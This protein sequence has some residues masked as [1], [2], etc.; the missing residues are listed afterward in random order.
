LVFSSSLLS[1][2]LCEHNPVVERVDVLDTLAS[3][4]TKIAMPG[5]AL[6]GALGALVVT[7][8]LC[9]AQVGTDLVGADELLVL[10]DD[11]AAEG[12]LLDHDRGQDETRADLDERDVGLA[13]VAGNRRQD[14]GVCGLVGV[15]GLDGLCGLLLGDLVAADPDLAVAGEGEA[16]YVVGE[17][18][19]F[20]AAGGHA[21]VVG[22]QFLDDSGVGLLVEAGVEAEDGAGALE[23]VAG[24]VELL[25]CVDVLAVHFDSR[26]VRRLGQPEVEILALAGLEEHD[27]V[28]VVEVGKLVELRELGLGVEFGVF[29]RVRKE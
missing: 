19:Y 1:I 14:R 29:A 10:V 3:P 2:P 27:V 22:E 11:G 7:A 25:G 23:A 21:E 18:F 28:A 24:E 8:G 13:L 20:A 5:L 6:G 12:A 9:P 16:H 4:E 17:G 15:A 26:A